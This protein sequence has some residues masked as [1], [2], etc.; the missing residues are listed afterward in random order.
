MSDRELWSAVDSYICDKLHISEDE[1]MNSVL[2]TNRSEGLPSIDVSAAQGKL[3][4]LL[5]LTR[6]SKRILEVGTLGGFS[7]I[8]L[9]RALQPGGKVTTLEYSPKHAQVA[10]SNIEKAGLGNLVDIKVGDAK[11]SLPLLYKEENGEPYDFIF[12]DADKPSYPI[13]L[14]WALKM[15]KPGTVIVLDNV[16]RRGAIVDEQSK[17]ES[18]IAARKIYD[19]ISS[20]SRL[21]A[22]AVQTVG[23]KGYDGFILA[24]VK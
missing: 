21:T 6:Q 24:T 17:D 12:I 10:K 15:S 1:V 9:A 7:T 16:V 11:E 23:S 13:Y 4:H 3:L 5:A 2:T 19:L 20:E 18:V 22:T 8:W 14:D